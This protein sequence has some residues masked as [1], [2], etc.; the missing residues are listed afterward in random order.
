MTI[1]HASS[2]QYL[3]MT[4]HFHSSQ[5]TIKTLSHEDGIRWKDFLQII[6]DIF[7]ASCNILKHV[8]CDPRIPT[9]KQIPG[10]S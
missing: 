5:I 4:H 8:W 2:S 3:I 6:L 7:K 9:I 1:H 10:C